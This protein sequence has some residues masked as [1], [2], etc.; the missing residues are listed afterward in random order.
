PRRGDEARALRPLRQCLGDIGAREPARFLDFG[1]VDR[2]FKA[3]GVADAADHQLRGERP[4]LAG[5]VPYVAHT[6]AGL[7]EH[8]ALDGLLDRLAR[9]DE[10]GERREAVRR[11]PRLAPEENLALALDE[12]D[13]HRVD[14]R[15][16]LRP[17]SGAVAL[18]AALG[19]RCRLPAARA[20]PVPRVP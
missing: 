3:V 11:K 13:R 1:A 15:K 16:M 6:H 8:L 17:A 20:E 10:A 7:L 9:L 2:Q 19:K 14:A 18:P 5:D 12:H 4:R